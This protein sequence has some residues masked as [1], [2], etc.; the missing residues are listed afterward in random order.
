MR[1]E[2]IIPK[3]GGNTNG[4]NRLNKPTLGLEFDFGPV[5]VNVPY[6]GVAWRHFLITCLLALLFVRRNPGGFPSQSTC[7]AAFWCFLCCLPEQ[8]VEQSLEVSVIL[9]SII[10]L[11]VLSVCV[12]QVHLWTT[13]LAH[14]H[15]SVNAVVYSCTN[16]DLRDIFKRTLAKILP[17]CKALNTNSS[18]TTNTSSSVGTGS[19]GINAKTGVSTVMFSVP[20]STGVAPVSR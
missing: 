3:I 4:I 20:M 10:I 17:W 13:L 14:M 9:G 7:N 11:M 15:S 5:V 19:S 16:S 6:G 2:L 18:N 1:P 12:P 8:A